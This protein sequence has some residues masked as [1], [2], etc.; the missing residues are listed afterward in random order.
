MAEDDVGASAAY[1]REVDEEAEER[2]A[3]AQVGVGGTGR[4][5]G[6][7]VGGG[8]GGV[9]FYRT[10]GGGGMLHPRHLCLLDAWAPASQSRCASGSSCGQ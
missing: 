7:C 8:W 5:R 4:G 2:R 6:A 9:D 10:Q 1:E 3:E